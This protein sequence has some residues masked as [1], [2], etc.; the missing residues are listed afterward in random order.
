M[1]NL[2]APDRSPLTNSGTCSTL[3]PLGLIL[4]VFVWV[5]IA[6]VKNTALPHD[7]AEQFVWAQTWQWGYPKHPPLPTWLFKLVLTVLPVSPYALYALS[8]ICIS[9]TGVLTYLLAFE[10]SGSR[11]A[12]VCAL[13]LWTLQQPFSWRAWMFNHN[14]AMV[15]C[16]ALTAFA[17]AKALKTSR[18]PWWGLVAVAAGLSM[19]T[20][21]QSALPLFGLLWVIFRTGQWRKPQVRHGVA[22][23]LAV[24]ALMI[25]PYFWWLFHGHADSI[26]YA[27][28]QLGAGNNGQSDRLLLF[29]LVNLR[30]LALVLIVLLGWCIHAMRERD[31]AE[32]PV[33]P[34]V[35]GKAWAEG[36][37]LIPLLGV[38]AVGLSGGATVPGHW[39]VQTFQFVSVALMLWFH[40][41]LSRQTLRTV[42]IPL[43]SLHVISMLVACSP[44]M[45]KLH[46]KGTVQ[47]YPAQEL[48]DRVLADWHASTACP[49]RYVVAPFF[50]GGQIAAMAPGFPAIFEDGDLSKSPWID[51]EDMRRKG[52]VVVSSRPDGLPDTAQHTPSM[53]LFPPRAQHE[54]GPV[55]W[56]VVLPAEP[57]KPA[58]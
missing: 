10:L 52:Y 44:Y 22:I 23:T 37:F 20:K 14:S 18:W 6:A 4:T 5:A 11:V 34:A 7:M 24:A 51:T 19:L 53:S 33:P 25:T 49:L 27:R 54:I 26:A 48:V 35:E 56:A 42:A 8:A 30:M 32:H 39:G 15:L 36:L 21:L 9:L 47:G 12:S 17:L 55:F 28:H 31:A 58:H 13:A 29:L 46:A 41:Q 50:V 38:V 45:D 2:K 57:C 43:V 3:L 16:V 1:A 40:S